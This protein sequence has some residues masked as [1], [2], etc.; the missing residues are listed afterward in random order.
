MSE[1]FCD[2]DCPSCGIKFKFS[3]TIE[4]MWRNT[5]KQFFCPNGHPLHWDK[6]KETADQ[7]ELKKLKVEVNELRTKLVAAEKQAEAQ[8]KR[9]DDLQTE[10]EIWR[11]TSAEP[12]TEQKAVEQ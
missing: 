9:A 10:L 11:P 5:E 7:K 12:T 6:P 4:E 8:K 1:E 3:K 2:V